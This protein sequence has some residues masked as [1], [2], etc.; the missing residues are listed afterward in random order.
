MAGGLDSG[1]DDLADNHEINVT[2]FIDVMLV[3]LIIFM[4]AAPLSTVD[5]AVDLP[6]STAK[7]QPRPDKPLF[8]TIKADRTL[9]LGNDPDTRRQALPARWM[10]RRNMDRQQR[11]FL[12]ADKSVPYGELMRVMNLLR[13]A[14]YLKVALVGLEGLDETGKPIPL[15]DRLRQA[16]PP[17]SACDDALLSQL[18]ESRRAR[19]QPMGR[20]SVCRLRRACRWRG[21]GAHAL[22]RGTGSADDAAGALVVE[23]APRAGGNPGRFA[24]CRARAAHA[25]SRA[26]APGLRKRSTDVAKDMPL[27]EPSPAPEPEVAL[28]TPRPEAKEEPKEEE[29]KEPVPE[30][31]NP[32]QASAAPLTM[33]PP[34]VEAQPAPSAA[35]PSPGRAPSLERVQASWQKRLIDHLNRHK[36]YPD[37]ARSRHAQGTVVVAFKL[38]RVGSARCLACHEKLRIA[39]LGRGSTRR[40]PAG[41][42]AAGASRADRPGRCSIWFCRSS[43][44]SSSGQRARSRRKVRGTQIVIM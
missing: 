1:E 40:A 9:A 26:D 19:D 21:A 43:S 16:G 18:L 37:A 30:Q 35:P 29:A 24:R 38:D 28:P 42:P 6:V 11:L 22:A 13:G 44:A 32:E 14:G 33:A 12:R 27:V 23:M 8:L 5:V 10:R 34:R 15:P 3:L 20:S 17:S 7:P 36:R 39:G 41:Q 31:Q 2:P 25:R 4:V